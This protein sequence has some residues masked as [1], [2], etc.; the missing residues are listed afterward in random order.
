[1]ISRKRPSAD[2]VLDAVA[3][4]LNQYWQQDDEQV[5]P[6]DRLQDDFVENEQRTYSESVQLQNE[7]LVFGPN[8]GITTNSVHE[9]GKLPWND[10]TGLLPKGMNL[11]M[12][13]TLY[14]KMLWITNNVPKMSLQKIARAGAEA[15]ADRLIA[16]HYKP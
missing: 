9:T 11:P 8:S 10:V 15:E 4:L 16:L 3:A 14:A 13:P 12:S 1:M 5:Q 6:Q 2:E 7:Q